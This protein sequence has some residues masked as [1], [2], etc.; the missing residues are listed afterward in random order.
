MKIFCLDLEGVL[1]PEIWI[2]TAKRFRMESLKLT[3]RDIPD[4]NKLMKYRIGILKKA[5]LRLKDIQ[6]VIAQI[7]PLPGAAAFL[8]Q[9][10]A[11]GPVVILSDTFLE[12]A[13]PLMKQLGYPALLCNSLKID[14]KGFISGFTLRQKDGKHKAALG[15]KKMGFKVYAAG[16]SFNDLTML[17]AADRG[18]LFNPPDKIRKSNPGL[19]AVYS[20]RDLLRRLSAS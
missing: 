7:R 19:P 6:K 8:N 20:H 10:R 9:L 15:F 4:Y 3:T 17:K 11:L 16:D 12:F 18:V 14:G 5:G 1:V 13:G 2:E